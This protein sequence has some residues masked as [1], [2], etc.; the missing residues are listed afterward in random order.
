MKPE[1]LETKEFACIADGLAHY[2]RQGYK[3]DDSHKGIG[4]IMHN[5]DHR[6]VFIRNRT[7]RRGRPKLLDVIATVIQL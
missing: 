1:I 6:E 5:A 2:Y 4:R 3:S 7:D